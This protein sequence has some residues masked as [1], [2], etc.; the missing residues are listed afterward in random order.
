[1]HPKMEIM[2]YLTIIFK[3]MV[4]VHVRSWRRTEIAWYQ[5]NMPGRS[6]RE[7]IFEK[8]VVRMHTYTFSI[9]K[10]HTINSDYILN[11]TNRI[12]LL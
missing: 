2:T 8:S 4:G 1:M 12:A 7:L 5:M 11:T 9:H 10:L 6:Y 3:V